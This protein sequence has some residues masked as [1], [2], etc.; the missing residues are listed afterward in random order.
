M[1]RCLVLLPVVLLLATGCASTYRPPVDPTFAADH[2][3]YQKDLHECEQIAESYS[4]DTGEEA[5]KKGGIGALAGAALGAAV[6]AATGAPGTGAAIGATT[7]AAAGATTN[8]LFPFREGGVLPLRG[9]AS[10]R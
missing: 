7:G 3:R 2:A 5:L 1:R 9:P 8:L 10:G 6:G 4:E